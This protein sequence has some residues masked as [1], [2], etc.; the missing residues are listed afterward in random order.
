[1]KIDRLISIIM[2]L[3]ERK[4]M[5][6]KSLSDMFEVSLRTIYRDMETINMAGI[7]IVSAP[8]VNGGFCIM[9]EYKVDKKVFTPADI[10]ALLMGLGSISPMLTREQMLGTLAKVKSLM[11]TEQ[12]REIELKSSQI[13]IDL[14]PWMGNAN[15]QMFLEMIKTAF[16]KHSLLSFQYSDRKGQMST[17][18]IEPYKLALKENHWYVQGFCLHKQDFRLFKLSRMSHLEVLD[19]TFT[20]RELP[21]SVSEFTSIMSQR[22]RPIQLLIHETLRDRMLDYCSSEHITPYGDHHFIVHFPFIA[23]DFGYHLLLSFGDQ[24]EYLEPPDIRAEMIRRIERMS[25]R[26]KQR[27]AIVQ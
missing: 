7:P 9:D 8:G 11:P 27:K 12:A 5:S 14:K 4:R 20:R 10:T 24:C 3:L 23:D 1:M 26:Y 19:K 18:K 6:A 13:M 15:L 21:E 16:Q 22:Q 25:Q 2:V 17:R